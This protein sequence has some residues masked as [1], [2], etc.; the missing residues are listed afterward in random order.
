MHT[1]AVLPVKRFADAKQRLSE[2]LAPATR[3]ALAEAMLTDVL[4]ALRRAERVDEVVVVTGE[5][6]AE[7][8]AHGYG[9]R[10]VHDTREAGQSAAAEIGLQ[11]AAGAD[12]VPLVPGDCPAL[13]PHEL[14]ELIGSAQPAP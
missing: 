14:D 12:M 3:R 11:A 4:I 2:G 8:L 13:T 5:P 10:V 6:A 9:A 7:A 1:V